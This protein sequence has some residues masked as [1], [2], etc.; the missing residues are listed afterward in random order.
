MVWCGI[1]KNSIIDSFF[2]DGTVSGDVYLCMLNEETIPNVLNSDGE[3]PTWFQQDGAPAHSSIHMRE[4]LHLQFPGHLI[5]LQGP[6]EWLA[7][8]RD[9]TPL[10]FYLWGHL[11][12]LVY[13]QKIQ[14]A[15]H[16]QERIINA[17]YTIIPDTIRHVIADWISH[18]H[19]CINHNGEHIEHIL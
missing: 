4:R 15:A 5:G 12:A 10:D 6:V 3:F 14:N 19:L 17:C 2:F 8:S 1:W 18:L 9:L 13:A 16:L 7:R 11:K